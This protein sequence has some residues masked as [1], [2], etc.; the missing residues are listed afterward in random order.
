[1]LKVR[2]IKEVTDLYDNKIRA[3][4]GKVY[5]LGYELAFGKA[6]FINEQGDRN[7][8]DGSWGWEHFVELP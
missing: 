3:V 8:F 5:E 6:F 7:Y 1:M 2:C 4:E